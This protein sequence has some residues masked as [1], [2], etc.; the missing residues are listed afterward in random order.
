MTITT[1]TRTTGFA[2]SA[3]PR[4]PCSRA[5]PIR[6]PPHSGHCHPVSARNGQGMPM[7]VVAY[8]TLRATPPV[9]IPAVTG[10]PDRAADLGLAEEGAATIPSFSLGRACRPVARTPLGSPRHPPLGTKDPM[11]SQQGPWPNQPG[12]PA[13]PAGGPGWTQPGPTNPPPPIYGPVPTHHSGGH[14]PAP[15]V[16]GPPPGY[17]TATSYPT[18][19]GYG[20]PPAPAFAMP[21]RTNYASW[22]KRVGAMLIDFTPV[23]IGLIIFS[24]GYVLW[25]FEFG[26]SAS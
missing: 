4:S 24:V 9:R 20:P 1:P 21:L 25:L 2:R 5:L 10:S 17:P 7:P 12:D 16:Y 6:V 18:V 13:V 23:Y 11:S 22:A 3:D 14:A 26:T 15:P 19:P 8:A